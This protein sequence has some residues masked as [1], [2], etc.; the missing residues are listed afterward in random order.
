MTNLKGTSSKNKGPYAVTHRIVDVINFCII[1]MMIK[2]VCESQRKRIH[3][4]GVNHNNKPGTADQEMF[5]V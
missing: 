5:I 1:I 4:Q 3:L 2:L